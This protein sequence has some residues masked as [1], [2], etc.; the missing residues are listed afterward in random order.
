[1]NEKLSDLGD[2]YKN[3]SL[4]QKKTGAT[5]NHWDQIIFI[6]K[7]WYVELVHYLIS[8]QLCVLQLGENMLAYNCSL[9]LCQKRY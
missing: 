2:I 4:E 3:S 6:L 7:D 1:M 5:S 9:K 8:P